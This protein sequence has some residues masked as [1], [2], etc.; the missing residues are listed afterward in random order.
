MD[1]CEIGRCSGLILFASTIYFL[2]DPFHYPLYDPIQCLNV[3]KC[4]VWKL[5]KWILVHYTV[6]FSTRDRERYM[7]IERETE[8]GKT[9]VKVDV[10]M[11]W[12]QMNREVVGRRR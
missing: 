7:K 4:I 5:C 1:L 3:V 6:W 10:K 2:F 12:K 8:K 9:S 11:I